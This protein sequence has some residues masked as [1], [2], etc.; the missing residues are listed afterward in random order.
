MLFRDKRAQV[1]LF[2]IIAIVAVSI[3]SMFMMFRAGIVRT[4]M[5]AENSKVLLASQTEP[6]RDYASD[7]I[8]QISDNYFQKAMISGGYYY[9]DNLYKIDYAGEK[10]ILAYKD[11]NND[12]VNILP[13]IEQ[14]CGTA[15]DDYMNREGY[16]ALDSCVKDFSSFKKYMDVSSSEERKITAECRDEEIV[17]NAEWP[18]TISRA[19]SSSVVKPKD[20]KLLIPLKRMWQFSNDIVNKEID[21][22]NFINTEI[23]EYMW[24][25]KYGMKNLLLESKSYPSWQQTLFFVTSKPY[26]TGEEENKFYF[27][28]DREI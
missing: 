23:E 16:E 26:R 2:V 9:S 22:K 5:S 21:D 28:V 1:T 25:H 27:A 10:V 3:I 17:I 20:A 13:S 11:N 24:A 4:P 14:I 15:F 7:C 8:E 6:L 19:D 12:F 18:I